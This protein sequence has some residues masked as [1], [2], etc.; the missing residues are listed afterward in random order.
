MKINISSYLL[1]FEGL[2]QV[3]VLQEPK[4]NKKAYKLFYILSCINSNQFIR[5]FQEANIKIILKKCT[6]RS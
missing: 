3:S 2:F 5:S 4:E 1:R 6:V